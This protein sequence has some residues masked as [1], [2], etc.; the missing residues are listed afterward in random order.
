MTGHRSTMVFVYG[1]PAVGKLTVAKLVAERTGFKLAHNHLV[2]DLV[3][4]LFSFGDEQFFE[5][6][7]RF[8]EQLV[9]AAAQVRVSFVVTYG[10]TP[11]DGPAV[12]RQFELV[13]SNGGRI[14]C[15]RLVAP[16]DVLMTRVADESR[17][18]HGKLA[19]PAVLE[20]VLERWDF[21]TPL[22][23]MASLTIDTAVVSPSEAAD[24]VVAHYGLP[25]LGGGT[26]GS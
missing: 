20:D 19:D 12:Q 21:D 5:L 8:R 17:R 7:N 15:V 13:R 2:I 3:G 10:Y 16:R 26:S 1:P 9:E 23:H 6:V 24:R 22:P 18:K 14:A 4:S 11:D 25:N